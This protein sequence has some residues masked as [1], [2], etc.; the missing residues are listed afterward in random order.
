MQDAN[1]VINVLIID[2]EEEACDNLKNI[3]SQ[4]I[5]SN[6]SVVGA[7]H[8]TV[9]GEELINKFNPDAVFLDIEMP[10]ENAFE[11]LER[12]HPFDFDIVFITAYDEFAIKAFRLNAIDYILKPIDID[13][14]A[15]AIQK[16]KDRIYYKHYV[17]SNARQVSVLK[18]I[19]NKELQHKLTLRSLNQ[20]EI[21]DFKDIYSIEG[22]GS[23]CKISFNKAG[24]QKEIITSFIIADYE[25]VLPAEL[26]Y[27]VHKS[28]LVN[29][30]Q[31]EKILINGSYSVV[32]K[33]NE[34]IPV[35]RRRYNDFI[36]FLKEN[37]FYSV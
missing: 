16:L 35:S 28:Y 25:D 14:L 33:S 24:V 12:I 27:R 21:V 3:L 15:N 11:F 23:Y 22:Q 17:Q 1:S 4:Y 32:L 18:Q 2:D 7:A 8:N 30:L 20:L 29:C 6:I 10:E 9:E 34:H 26:F 5:D 36:N 31:I 37:N 13:D 19:S